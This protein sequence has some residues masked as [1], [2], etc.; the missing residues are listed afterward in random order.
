M[1]LI[2][3]ETFDESYSSAVAAMILIHLDASYGPQNI[4]GKVLSS[5]RWAMTSLL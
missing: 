2:P 4:E 5:S 1:T 3:D